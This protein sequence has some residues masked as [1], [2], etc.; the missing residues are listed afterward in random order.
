MFGTE[1][2]QLGGWSSEN[3]GGEHI[4]YPILNVHVVQIN[5]TGIIMCL[6]INVFTVSLLEIASAVIFEHSPPWG[7]QARPRPAQVNL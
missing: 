3:L 2:V 5:F 7:C 6:H 4:S 1:L